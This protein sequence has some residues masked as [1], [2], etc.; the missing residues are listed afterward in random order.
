M[1]LHIVQQ[2]GLSNHIALQWARFLSFPI[3]TRSKSGASAQ[4]R[5]DQL[6]YEVVV[7]PEEEGSRRRGLTCK[8][9][10]KCTDN[11]MPVQLTAG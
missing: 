8:M 5:R 7:L 3:L 1:N 4:Q 6:L 11:E 9:I 10:N 2:N